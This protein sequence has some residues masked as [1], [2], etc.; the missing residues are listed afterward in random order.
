MLRIDIAIAT[1]GEDGIRK[2]EKLLLPPDEN[3]RYVV[4]WQDYGEGNLPD[5]I[6]DRSDVGVFLFD[7]CGVSRNRN[8]AIEHCN[9]D[10]IVMADDDIT[11]IHGFYEEVSK[12]FETDSNLDFAIF[13]YENSE[14]KIYPLFDCEISIPFPKNYYGSNIEFAIRRE[15]LGN[16]RYNPE[17]GFDAPYF[18]SG[19]D[20]FF[21]ISAIKRGL[22]V[23]FINKTICKHHGVS[24]GHKPN[25]GVLR[26]MGFVIRIIYPNS[27][28]PRIF[29]KGYRVNRQ[30]NISLGS[31]I[32][33]MLEGAYGAKR[34]LKNTPQQFKW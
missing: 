21:L 20:E 13:K 34:R 9:G 12:A 15:S 28:I 4:S 27:Y 18:Q 26:S 22:K 33:T 29:L 23:K 3:V 10:I 5:S 8:N 14:G 24:T 32:K 7:G 2:V 16:L 25:K 17:L 6:K 30:N 19:E 11:Y 1:H 31:A